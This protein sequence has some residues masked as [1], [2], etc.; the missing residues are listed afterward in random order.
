MFLAT[1]CTVL[2]LASEG[3]VLAVFLCF[4]CC[5]A[6]SIPVR[7]WF[8]TVMVNRGHSTVPPHVF[9]HKEPTTPRKEFDVR[10][11]SRGSC[12]EFHAVVWGLDLVQSWTVGRRSM[13]PLS[14]LALSR[15]CPGFAYLVV[16]ATHELT[17]GVGRHFLLCVP[18]FALSLLLFPE[19]MVSK[20]RYCPFVPF[21]CP[22]KNK[23]VGNSTG[24]SREIL[25][26]RC[27]RGLLSISFSEA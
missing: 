13:P 8:G 26:T 2:R 22:S 3:G 11:N 10:E 24:V 25:V 21:I 23:Q 19:V 17:N 5:G 9:R 18:C 7:Y 16:R 15:C 20:W 4:S 6:V 12:V 27:L 14:F 1:V